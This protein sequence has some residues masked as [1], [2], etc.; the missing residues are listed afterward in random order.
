MVYF[1][2]VDAFMVELARVLVFVWLF[3]WFILVRVGVFMVEL[4]IINCFDACI[5]SFYFFL[6]FFCTFNRQSRDL[7]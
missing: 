4:A 6:G 7:K 1:V 2:R 3:S 5:V